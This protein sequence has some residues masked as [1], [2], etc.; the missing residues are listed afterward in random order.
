MKKR[1][2]HGKD[3][4]GWAWKFSH[5]KYIGGALFG[6]TRIDREKPLYPLYSLTPQLR[7]KW[8]RVKFV[9]VK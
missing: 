3:W 4:H 1:L 2:K 6:I 7:G 9:E 8:V 5:P